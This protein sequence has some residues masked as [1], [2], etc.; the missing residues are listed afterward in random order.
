MVKQI[1]QRGVKTGGGLLFS[2]Q[3]TILS[4]ALV[5]GIMLFAS[6]LLGL[7]KKRLYAGIIT[8]GPELDAFFAAFRLPDLVFQLLIGGSLNAAFIPVFTGYISQES[9]KSAWEFVSATLNAV[10]VGFGL[11]GIVAFFFADKLALLVGSG[12][13]PEQME[14]LIRLMKIL[15]ISPVLLGVSSF[16][17]GTLQAFQRFFMP[18]LAP[19]LYNLGAIFG[20]VVLYPIMGLEGA[21]WGVVIGS[22]CHFLVQLPALWHLGF[23]YSLKLNFRD[24]QLIRI[25]KLSIPRTLGIGVEQI[26]TLVLINIASHLPGGAI[27]FFDLG[28]SIINLPISILGVSIAQA[29]LPQF[30][31]LYAQKDVKNLKK[32]FLSSFNQIIFF[33]LPVSVILIVLKIPVVRLIYG[34]GKFSWDDTVLTAWVVALLSVGVFAQALN[35]LVVRFFYALHETRKPVLVGSIGMFI[36]LIVAIGLI[37]WRPSLGVKALALSVSAGAVIELVLLMGLLVKRGIGNF[38]EFIVTPIKMV[39]SAFIMALVVYVPVRVLDQVFI[40]TTR[41]VN[42]VILVWLVTSF[43]LTSYLL[44][45]W[46]LGV[47]ELKVVLRILMKAR[48]FQRSVQKVFK[49]P[50]LVSATIDDLPE[51]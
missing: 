6:A 3:R 13:S 12:F 48:S 34:A 4:G 42:L 20:I 46:L 9:K 31:A 8:P 22:L 28:Q 35:N 17:A 51:G 49:S 16:V 19:L 25:A 40:D 21:A 43:G 2:K 30:S 11:L 32:T 45:T 29:S 5:I 33:I 1:L 36:S 41:V 50:G 39:V 24:K 15:L 26:K 44:S 23:K 37:W 18:F 14:L 38:R 10:L 47:P 7:V 27:S